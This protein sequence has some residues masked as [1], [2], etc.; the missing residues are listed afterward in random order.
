MKKFGKI[1][2]VIG[3]FLT[4]IGNAYAFQKVEGIYAD[5][6]DLNVL[7]F[8][9]DILYIFQVGIP[10]PRFNVTYPQEGIMELTPVEEG[11]GKFGRWKYKVE[12]NKFKAKDILNDH[13]PF[14]VYWR[15]PGTVQTIVGFLY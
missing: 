14:T 10:G 4:M 12:G 2:A 11:R 1:C 15:E 13:P 9:D 7:K 8:E 6:L 5:P 3:M